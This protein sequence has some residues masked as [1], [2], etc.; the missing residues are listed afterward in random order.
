M[1]QSIISSTLFRLRQIASL[2]HQLSIAH[3]R[4]EEIEE[5]LEA[6]KERLRKSGAEGGRSMR[7]SEDR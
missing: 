6:M 4:E 5:D 3:V 2:R 1:N 7:D